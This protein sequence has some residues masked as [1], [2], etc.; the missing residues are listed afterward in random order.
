M[1]RHIDELAELY[2]LGSLDSRDRALVERHTRTCVA[3]ANRIR[4]AEETIAFM[5]DLEEHHKPPRAIFQNFAVRLAASRA[6][7]KRLSGKVIGTVLG[8]IVLTLGLA[9]VSGERPSTPT[10]LA[11]ANHAFS[12]DAGLDPRATRLWRESRE[13]KIHYLQDGLSLDFSEL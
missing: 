5:A 4:A 6:A 9:Y 3:C 10:A 13:T 2:A 8:A 7:Q 11:D 1:I 12:G